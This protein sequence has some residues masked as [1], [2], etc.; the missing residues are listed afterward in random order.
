MSMVTMKAQR[1]GH[2]QKRVLSSFF[3]VSVE[4]LADILQ[5]I[6][7]TYYG[8][9]CLGTGVSLYNSGWLQTCYVAQA[10]F[11]SVI[12]VSESFEC[13]DC[14]WEPT[15]FARKVLG[16]KNKNIFIK[17]NSKKKSED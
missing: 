3:S 6:T 8:L 2:F 15:P 11:K 9:V 16:K 10:H 7:A 12:L 5:L 14:W 17:G 4:T 13:W 1:G